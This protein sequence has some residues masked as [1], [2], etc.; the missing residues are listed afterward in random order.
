MGFNSKHD[1]TLLAE[2]SGKAASGKGPVE[3]D[4]VSVCDPDI[5]CGICQEKVGD[6]NPEGVQEKWAALPC[7]HV[8]GNHCIKTFFGMMVQDKPTCPVCRQTMVHPACGHPV[9]PKTITTR[10]AKRLRKKKVRQGVSLPRRCQF[11][12][13]SIKSMSFSF[14]NAGGFMYSF[15]GR[16]VFKTITLGIGKQR[17]QNAENSYWQGW[18]KINK[19]G[20][21]AW[22]AAQLPATDEPARDSFVDP[23]AA[24]TIAT[25]ITD[26]TVAAVQ[27][28]DYRV[29]EGSA[30]D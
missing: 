28:G 8:Y 24:N 19:T 12:T 5:L 17:R 18:R 25:D 29:L 23:E 10:E 21:K 7:G 2:G 30:E 6:K 11:C 4:A 15:W 22:W 14:K 9:L 26:E 16:A 13:M 20:F 27:Q 1:K 3:V